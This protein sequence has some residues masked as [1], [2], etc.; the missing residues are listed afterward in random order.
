MLS[1]RHAFHAG[2][3][4]DVLKHATLSLVLNSFK[5]KDKPFVYIDTHAGGGIYDLDSEWARKTKESNSGVQRIW[6]E[7]SKWPELTDYFQ[8]LKTLNTEQAG[9]QFYPGSP[10][11]ACQLLRPQDRLVLMELH[12]QEIEVLRSH[13]ARDSRVN[14]HHRD[15]LEGLTALTP[16]TPRRGLVLVDPAYERHE[17]YTQVVQAVKKAYTR[18]P[19]GTYIIWYPMLAKARDRSLRLLHDLKEKSSFESLLVA[20]LSVEAQHPDLGMHGSGLA[21]INPPWQLDQQLTTLLPRLAKTLQLDSQSH[22][23]VEWLMRAV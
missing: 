18:W 2:N 11:V 22:W 20:D 17:E 16:P 5:Q 14:I 3:H 4:A 15:G 8:I 10:E 23:R 9:Q 7:Q 19:T 13:L 1:Y 12:P 21:I 6:H